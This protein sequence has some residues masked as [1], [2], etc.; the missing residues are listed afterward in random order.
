[1]NTTPKRRAISNGRKRP[2]KRSP[3]SARRAT[4]RRT[5]AGDQP[6]K[7]GILRALRRSPLVGANLDLSRPATSGRQVD[8]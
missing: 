3:D 8:L 2:A 4:A 5:M 6:E 7:G 1:M